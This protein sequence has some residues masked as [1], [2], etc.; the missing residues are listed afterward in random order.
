MPA[1]LQVDESLLIH[2]TRRMIALI[3]LPKTLLLM[4]TL[5]GTYIEMP[6]GH[7]W[8][9]HDSELARL[10]GRNELDALYQEFRAAGRKFLVPKADKI[11]KQ[12]RDR[13][14]CE[15]AETMSE[16][17]Q[18]LKYRLTVRQIQTIRARGVLPLRATR[19]V[20]Q[21]DLFPMLAPVR[22]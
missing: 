21:F 9:R 18:A 3:G 5:G 15:T 13:E 14:I 6:S 4:E 2:K 10:I 11:L 12:L 20:D 17:E 22:D 16:R 19:N 7:S 1:Q 8:R